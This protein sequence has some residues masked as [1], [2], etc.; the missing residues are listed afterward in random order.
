[1]SVRFHF[2][3]PPERYRD[4]L[5]SSGKCSLSSVS[6]LQ[7]SWASWLSAAAQPSSSSSTSSARARFTWCCSSLRSPSSASAAFILSLQAVVCEKVTLTSRTI[8]WQAG[9]PG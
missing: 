2:P 3:V 9:H 6:C 5:R 4:A 7:T 1:M 8:C